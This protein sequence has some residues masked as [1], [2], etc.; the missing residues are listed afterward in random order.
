ML[1]SFYAYRCVCSLNIFYP[2]LLPDDCFKLGSITSLSLY[3][4]YR[5]L[6]KTV[7]LRGHMT[8]SYWL[9]AANRRLPRGTL[10]RC[11]N[12]LSFESGLSW[13][14]MSW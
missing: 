6:A 5:A 14:N 1:Q 7:S 2:C 11:Y 10:E 8:A 12:W 13:P 9:R 4:Y 3:N